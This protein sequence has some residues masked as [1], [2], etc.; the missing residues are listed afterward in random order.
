[1][2]GDP[3][4]L[5]RKRST[6]EGLDTKPFE[7]TVT[8][9][10]STEEAINVDG[11]TGPDTI[12]VPHP[13]LGP[14]SWVR[15]VPERGARLIMTALGEGGRRAGLSYYSRQAAE[16]IKR[17]INGA[18]LYRP[19][20]G[21]EWEM[22]TPKVAHVLGT[23][24]GRLY[25][26]G[27]P[28]QQ[29]LDP[30]RLRIRARAPTH[31]RE[32]HRHIDSEL[33]NEERL[34]VVVRNLTPTKKNR[35]VQVVLEGESDETTYKGDSKTKSFAMEYL[36]KF[37]RDGTAL[38]EVIQGDCFDAQGKQLTATKTGE[39]LRHRSLLWTKGADDNVSYEV[40]EQG[41]VALTAPGKRVDLEALVASLLV[42]VANLDAIITQSVNINSTNAMNLRADSTARIA[43]SGGTILGPD[44]SPVDH[45]IRGEAFVASVISP[46]LNVL[47][48][49]FSG[50]SAAFDFNAFK[51]L[52]AAAATSLSPI[53]GAVAGTLSTNV[54][55]ST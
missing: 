24:D 28:V 25:L 5:S 18:G 29:Q 10:N 8:G 47:V 22:L 26:R 9:V 27:G 2:I 45:V 4:Q 39:K 33:N 40:D 23:V 31:K 54:K 20:K 1:M 42:R 44:P 11:S 21:G 34:G 3:S 52:L 30:V 36:R 53:Q 48:S 14:N 19:L 46:L 55:T 17:Y 13:M 7:V 6:D 49:L 37:G 41:S 51:P 43:G 16:Y 32:L 12:R 50:G 38:V 35:W 15:S